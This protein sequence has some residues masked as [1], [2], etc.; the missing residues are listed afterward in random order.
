MV[1]ASVPSFVSPFL[2]GSFLLFLSL[3]FS[4]WPSLRMLETEQGGRRFDSL[5]LY[6]TKIRHFQVNLLTKAVLEERER[7]EKG[8]DT[9]DK[10]PNKG[11]EIEGEEEEEELEEQRRCDERDRAWLLTKMEELCAELGT[12][13]ERNE[14]GLMIRIA[15]AGSQQRL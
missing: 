11:Q 5:Q 3:S 13:T 2:G 12:R 10:V 14:Q 4:V 15:P 9:G 6:P 1:S 8:G 7:G